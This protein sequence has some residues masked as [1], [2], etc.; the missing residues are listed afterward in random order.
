M[1]WIGALALVIGV[2]LARA[3]A[4][5]D[6]IARGEYLTRIGGCFSCH[7][8]AANGGPPLAGGRALAT[9][10]G[11]FYSPN[12]TPDRETGIGAWTEAQFATRMQGSTIH[13][14]GY[15]RWSRNIAVALG[16]APPSVQARASLLQRR[17]EASQLL[18]E[19]IDWALLQHPV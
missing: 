15:E 2:L 11:T 7:T 17:A 12:I 5:E 6:L 8:D 9:P 13:R 4:A 10:F 16:N 3:G 14:I 18:R 1:R 19:H